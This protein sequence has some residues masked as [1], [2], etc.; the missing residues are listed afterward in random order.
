MPPK[1]WNKVTGIS[2]KTNPIAETVGAP[3]ATASGQPNSKGGAAEVRLY[4]TRVITDNNLLGLPD[5]EIKN[6]ADILVKAETT[7]EIFDWCGTLMLGET[8]AAEIVKR[9]EDSGL[10]FGA[11]AKKAASAAK[12][13]QPGASAADGTNDADSTS[14]ASTASSST[15]KSRGKGKPL[16]ATVTTGSLVPGTLFECGC[17]ASTH[18]YKGTCM[19]CG[20]IICAQEADDYCYYCGLD[21]HVCVAYE[22]KK[23]QG[24]IN[25]AAQQRNTQNYQRALERRDKLLT[26]A[27]ERAKRTVV[28]DDQAGTHSNSAWLTKEERNEMLEAERRKVTELH[29]TTGAYAVHLDIVSQSVALGCS[30]T[31]A[32]A[33]V[34]PAAASSSSGASGGG[35]SGGSSL[36]PSNVHSSIPASTAPQ[37]SEDDDDDDDADEGGQRGEDRV[38]PLPTVLQKIWYS[39]DGSKVSKPQPKDSTGA[40]PRPAP[41]AP[42]AALFRNIAT[43]CRVQND[44]FAEDDDAWCEERQHGKQ[45][46]KDQQRGEDGEADV[47]YLTF[48]VHDIPSVPQAADTSADVFQPIVDHINATATSSSSS[49]SAPTTA[50]EAIAAAKF[51]QTDEAMCLSMHQPWASLLVA[52]IKRHEGRSW[53]TDFRG[54]LWIHAAGAKPTGIEDL[55]NYYRKFPW[56]ADAKFPTHYPTSCLL[57]YVFVTDCLDNEGYVRRFP[58]EEREESADFKFIC[59]RPKAL[60]FPLQMEGNHKIF[61]L[62][63]RLWMAARKQLG[64]R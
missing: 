46:A 4:I 29:R 19:N 40:A 56:N 30:S 41:E 47:S 42:K 14:T 18:A 64:E 3:P 12:P 48:V 50:A 55:E 26:F 53:P 2:T 15:K 33:A 13:K 43:S 51:W 31:A 37:L 35:G 39:P 8:V 23:E 25:E 57:G 58:A 1:T 38:M 9:R 21:T 24:L 44:Y 45:A 63:R 32:A 27:R 49:G 54:K 59:E 20:R 22:L 6:M 62:D 61:K 17:F 52:G 7:K 5:T 11:A 10:L 34:P 36:N 60:L 16:Q 28:I